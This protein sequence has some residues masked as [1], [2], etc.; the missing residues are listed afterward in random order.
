MSIRIPVATFQPRRIHRR[1]LRSNLSI[2]INSLPGGLHEEH[3]DLYQRYTRARHEDGSMADASPQEYTSFLTADWCETRFLELREKDRLI[4][5]AV[6]DVV[7]GAL[8]AVYTFFD[9]DCEKRSPGTL[10]ILLQIEEARSLDLD[11]LYLGYW[12]RDCRKMAYKSN[13]R[14][15][16]Y[17]RRGAWTTLTAGQQPPDPDFA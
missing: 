15:L 9:P 3:Y 2:R 13:F 12:V 11:Y 16:E 5:V 4:A 7:E 6:T 8:S 17:W 1:V 14:P 10:A